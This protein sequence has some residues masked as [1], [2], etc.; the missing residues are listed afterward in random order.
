MEGIRTGHGHIGANTIHL[1]ASRPSNMLDGKQYGD[2][3]GP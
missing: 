2:V 3:R 1:H